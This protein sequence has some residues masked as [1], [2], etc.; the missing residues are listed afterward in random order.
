MASTLNDSKLLKQPPN[1]QGNNVRNTSRI[2]ETTEHF[3]KIVDTCTKDEEAEARFLK[4]GG[5][6]VEDLLN[7]FK[8]EQ[9]QKSKMKKPERIEVF[10]SND[11]PSKEDTLGSNAEV[12]KVRVQE[13]SET[14]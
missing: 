10:I 12:V 3:I 5:V 1:L 7:K 6:R 9:K 13:C 2:L 8:S 11:E 14:D 4:R